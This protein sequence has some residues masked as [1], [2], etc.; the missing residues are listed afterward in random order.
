MTLRNLQLPAGISSVTAFNQQYGEN[1]VIRGVEAHVARE[2]MS[3]DPRITEFVDGGPDDPEAMPG[4]D[5]RRVSAMA[6]IGSMTRPELFALAKQMGLAV[7]ATTRSETLRENILRQVATMD[8]DKVPLIV[9]T[10]GANDG[11]HSTLSAVEQAT[12]NRGNDSLGQKRGIA[13]PAGGSTFSQPQHIP[14]PAN[15][16][17]PSGLGQIQPTGTQQ[18]PYN[19]LETTTGQPTGNQEAAPYPITVPPINPQTGQPYEAGDPRIPV[20]ALPP[21]REEPEVAPHVL[22]AV[23][24]AADRINAAVDD[25]NGASRPLDT[26]AERVA[27]EETAKKAN[28]MKGTDPNHGNDGEGKKPDDAPLKN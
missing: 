18:P 15:E 7:P 17:A 10:T 28:A 9:G 22:H 25:A 14:A 3:H 13:T 27:R 16:P 8:E 2:I 19:Q 1:G 26:E 6:K 4:A 5:D 21:V 12:P 11:E 23:H 20:T 24:A